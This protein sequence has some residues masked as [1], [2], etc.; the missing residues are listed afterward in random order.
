MNYFKKHAHD[1]RQ[2]KGRTIEASKLAGRFDGMYYAIIDGLIDYDIQP[3]RYHKVVI[4]RIVTN[5]Y[6]NRF[7]FK[8]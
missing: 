2:Y 4:R 3:S 5:H 8:V 7:P 1:P 6:Y